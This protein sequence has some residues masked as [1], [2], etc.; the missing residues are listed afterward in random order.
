MASESESSS[1][2]NEEGMIDEQDDDDDEWIGTKTTF[3]GRALPRRPGP[4]CRDTGFGS[5]LRVDSRSVACAD[6]RTQS[7]ASQHAAP[8]VFVVVGGGRTAGADG[9]ETGC[10]AELARELRR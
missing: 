4:D 5:T 9:A 10:A 8:A 7:D 2:P 3:F 6:A 1:E